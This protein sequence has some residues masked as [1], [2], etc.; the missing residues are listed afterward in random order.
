MFQCKNKEVDRAIADAIQ[1]RQ[2]DEC[3]L[4]V[5]GRLEFVNDHRAESAIYHRDCNRR[6]RSN[7]KKPGVDIATSCRKRG[8]P[9]IN[10]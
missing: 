8:R 9:T 3:F 6:F 1:R 4:E 5:K 10:E 7:K 2:N